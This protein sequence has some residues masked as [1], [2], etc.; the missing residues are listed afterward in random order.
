MARDSLLNTGPLGTYRRHKT[1]TSGQIS[2]PRMGRRM[3]KG[4]GKASLCFASEGA[5]GGRL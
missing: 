5:S 1:A 4:F 3:A 2:R